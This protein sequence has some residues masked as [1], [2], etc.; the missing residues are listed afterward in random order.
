MPL[1]LCPNCR[2]PVNRSSQ[3]C[4][5]CTTTLQSSSAGRHV[6]VAAALALVATVAVWATR[7]A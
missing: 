4:P 1:I 2:L 5:L 7:R 3:V 6:S